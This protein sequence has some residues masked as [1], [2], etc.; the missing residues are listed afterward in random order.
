[1]CEWL[2]TRW[3]SLI[4]FIMVLA[5]GYD[6]KAPGYNPGDIILRRFVYLLLDQGFYGLPIDHGPYHSA[7]LL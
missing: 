6:T 7:R 3:I 1:M 2:R 5:E 4:V